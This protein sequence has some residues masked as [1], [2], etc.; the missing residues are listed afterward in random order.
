MQKKKNQTSEGRRELSRVNVKRE[1]KSRLEM[2]TGGHLPCTCILWPTRQI[3]GSRTRS[4]VNIENN[5]EM[6]VLV[7]WQPLPRDLESQWTSGK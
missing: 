3:L 5:A 4:M 7:C 6:E 2:I 1:V